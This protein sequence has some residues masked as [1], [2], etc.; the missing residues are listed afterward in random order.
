M[1]AVRDT[2]PAAEPSE[3]ITC[4][5]DGGALG[6]FWTAMVLEALLLL[7]TFANIFLA[8]GLV[9]SDDLIGLLM[10]NACF[11]PLSIMS[12]LLLVRACI[13]ADAKGLR[14]R[15]ISRW[16]EVAWEDVT[17]FYGYQQS[18]S[19]SSSKAKL[20]VKVVGLYGS[21]VLV[22]SPEEWSSSAQLLVSIKQHAREAT[23]PG[24]SGPWVKKN[25]ILPLRCRY[26]TAV[27]RNTLRWL[28][29]LHKYGLAAVAAYFALQWFT[30]HTLPGWEWLLTPTGLFV[31]MK[32]TV[33]LVLRPTYRATQP[34]LGDKVIADQD[35][36]RFV[37]VQS[38]TTVPWADIT[39]FYRAGIRSV[40]V[41]TAG[42]FDFLDT[43]TDAERLRAV[44]PLLAVNAGK[45]GWRRTGGRYGT[46]RQQ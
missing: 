4:R 11:L 6:I 17:A 24:L 31:I 26:D 2:N 27:N 8:S 21:P 45:T 41:T 40:V 7:C 3:T 18:G 32:Q 28:D 30:T 37:T 16:R 46:H 35:S 34:R 19:G 39:D 10:L 44:I 23:G 20:S 29:N 5:P 36:L 33:P 1:D 25:S 9:W 12:A 42:K 14:W 43:L 38:D 22:L 13:I 15:Q